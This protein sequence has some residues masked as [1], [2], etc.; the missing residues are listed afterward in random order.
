MLAYVETG[1][2]R[3][4]VEELQDILRLH[5]AREIKQAVEQEMEWFSHGHMTPGNVRIT[6]PD[7]SISGF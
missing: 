5:K 1:S 4:D 6:P 3:F 2:E 7:G